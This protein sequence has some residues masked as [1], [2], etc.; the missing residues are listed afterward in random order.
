MLIHCLWGK[1]CPTH[2][3]IWTGAVVWASVASDW[4]PQVPAG[5]AARM[6]ETQ[7]N[8]QHLYRITN[9]RL[10]LMVALY[11]LHLHTIWNFENRK[12]FGYPKLTFSRK[13]S[14]LSTLFLRI[15]SNFCSAKNC[16]PRTCGNVSRVWAHGEPMKLVAGDESDKDGENLIKN[17]ILSWQFW[18][19]VKGFIN[20]KIICKYFYEY[21]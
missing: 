20:T 14:E 7:S 16:S 21:N 2:R 5:S 9:P 4:G 19:K 1:K 15:M 11:T 13:N 3:H 18:L 12:N 17:W 10:V 8:Y 6:P